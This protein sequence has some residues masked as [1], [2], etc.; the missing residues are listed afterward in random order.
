MPNTNRAH[1]TIRFWGSDLEPPELTRLL[2]AEPSSAEK[3]SYIS[4]SGT[5]VMKQA[6][7]LV[8]YDEDPVSVDVERQLSTLL[9]KLTDDLD[10]WRQLASQFKVDVFC[11]IF[12]DNWNQKDEAVTSS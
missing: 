5:Q 7:W 12:A 6:F 3:T 10:V 8:E 4:K 11:A 9:D 1:V 2:A